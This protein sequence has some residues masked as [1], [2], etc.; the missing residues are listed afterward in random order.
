MEENGKVAFEK[1]PSNFKTHH[2]EIKIKK[3]LKILLP[4][5]HQQSI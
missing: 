1:L 4:T 5:Y 3:Y 2:A